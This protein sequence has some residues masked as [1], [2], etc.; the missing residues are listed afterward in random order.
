[1][2]R[3]TVGWL[4]VAAQVALFVVLALLPWRTPSIASIVL[5]IPFVV[6]GGWLG[7][8]AFHALGS[9][10][11][12]TPVPIDG[13]GLRTSGPYSRIRHPIYTAVLSFTL[14]ALIAA[15]SPWSW[16]WG[17]VIVLFFWGKSRWEDRLLAQEYGPEWHAW[18]QRTGALIPRRRRSAP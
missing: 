17:V 12:P 11:T 3:H 16:V 9:A 13:A 2:N 1:M 7:V 5:A 4:L 6:L 8:A 14:A 18:A 15:G 10:L